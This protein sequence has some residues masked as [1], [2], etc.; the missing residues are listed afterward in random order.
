MSK[1]T[2][3]MIFNLV[4]DKEDFIVSS[5]GQRRYKVVADV[6]KR[7]IRIQFRKG[8]SADRMFNLAD[9]W[10]AEILWAK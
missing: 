1:F 3:T 2:Y 5:K 9:I 10:G 7:T 8:T 4:Q 6:D